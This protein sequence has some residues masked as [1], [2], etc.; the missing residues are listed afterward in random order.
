[1]NIPAPT[2]DLEKVKRGMY[3]TSSA[4]LSKTLRE[5]NNLSKSHRHSGY[6]LTHSMFWSE[7]R[8]PGVLAPEHGYLLLVLVVTWV[9]HNGWMASKVM[10]ARKQ[11]NIKYPTLYA[12][13]ESESDKK[14]VIC[15]FD[16]L[17]M[18]LSP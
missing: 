5:K 10:A 13:G 9:V 17:S 2:S 18:L 15:S 16:D 8:T 6:I 1:M 7:T 12:V 4:S 3:Y 11:Y 14:Y